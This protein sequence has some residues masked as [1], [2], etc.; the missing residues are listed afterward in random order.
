M[1]PFWLTILVLSAGTIVIKAAGP[2]LLGGRALPARLNGVISLLAP[3][4]L[5]A[6]LAVQTFG[7]SER[8]L[9][10]DERVVGLAAAAIAL[11]LKRGLTVVI[12]V[13]A[14]ATA[15]ARALT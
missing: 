4:L 10:V 6:L 15:L 8:G 13:A 9:V 3:A 2:V 14:I 5:A 11:A 7:T 1:S 12:L